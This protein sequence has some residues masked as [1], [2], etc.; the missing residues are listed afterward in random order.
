VEIV[1][2]DSQGKV[3]NTFRYSTKSVYQSI[4]AL[5][6][7]VSAASLGGTYLMAYAILDIP[8]N[9]DTVI[10]RVKPFA[11]QNGRTYY[12]NEGSVEYHGSARV[13]A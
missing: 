11:V 10:F 5:G 8:D 2:E 12:G 1:V 3:L 9:L 4:L 6:K 13:G 7:P